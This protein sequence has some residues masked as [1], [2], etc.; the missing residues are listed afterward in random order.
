MNKKFVVVENAG[1]EGEY[2]HRR[3]FKHSWEASKWMNERFGDE[4][5][6]LH[7]QV[8]EEL[9]NGDLTYDFTY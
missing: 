7:F 8:A 3:T 6:A 9:P 5:E 4:V 2:V 1:Y